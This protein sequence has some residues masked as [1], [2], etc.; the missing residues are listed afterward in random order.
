ML[1]EKIKMK[2]LL[3]SVLVRDRLHKVHVV[4]LSAL[5][6]ELINRK[7]VLLLLAIVVGIP[8]REGILLPSV[9]MPVIIIKL[10]TVLL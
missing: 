1:E 3:L 4:S 8:D 6:R 10:E 2:S 5:N 9:V 7:K